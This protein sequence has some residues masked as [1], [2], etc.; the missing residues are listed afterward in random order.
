MNR[1]NSVAALGLLLAVGLAGC[2]DPVTSSPGTILEP[3]FADAGTTAVPGRVLLDEVDDISGANHQQLVAKIQSR[4]PN[5][6]IEPTGLA[7][8]THIYRVTVEPNQTEELMNLVRSESTVEHVE[9]SFQIEPYFEPND[10][11]YQEQWGMKKIH[12]ESSWNYSAGRGVVVAVI[13]TGV[14]C[15][16]RDGFK[17]LSDLEQTQCVPGWNFVSGHDHAYDDHGHGSHVAGTIAQST[18]NN[19]G[20]VGVAYQVRIMPIKVLA[21][22][23]G[24]TS[25]NVADGIRWAADH[26][27]QVI[28]MSLG[29]SQRSAVIEE[30]CTHA[31]KKGVTIVA[32]AGN[33][34]PSNNTVG[35]PAGYDHVIAVSA[36]D[37][38]G[39]ITSFS[40]RGKQVDIGAPGAAIMQQT[41][42]PGGK[43]EQYATWNGTSMASPHVAG[44]AALVVS[45][46]V[47]DPDA[48]EEIL[49]ESSESNEVTDGNPQLYGAG[50]LDASAAMRKVVI[51]QGLT[52]LGLLALFSGILYYFLRRKEENSAQ[53]S[54]L[55]LESKLVKS[56]FFVPAL[57]SSVGFFFLPMLGLHLPMAF[58]RP[59]FDLDLTLGMNVHQW[60]PLATTLIPAGLTVLTWKW[61]IARIL[62]G[63]LAMGSATY[64]ASI[65]ALGGIWN[66]LGFIFQGW[67]ALN[68]VGSMA[69]AYWNLK[70]R[71]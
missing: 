57:L 38:T 16:T 40:S 21:A 67:I 30:A 68:L 56:L 7:E 70:E 22:Q 59:L 52:K 65:L 64:L 71:I 63:G 20:G 4:F 11:M 61:S 51:Q 12:T 66:P 5:A 32:A 2:S 8:E 35:Y 9:P 37:S 28:N 1:L 17:K 53:A 60:L 33:S 27:A 50:L 48:V 39:K 10:P 69:L 46:G 23:G 14:A 42:T 36:I 31:Y 24:G 54:M 25:E 3:T 55:S 62:N 47:N 34:G 26:G 6:Q 49:K 41:V 29:S 13:D 43:G 58:T 45:M 18:N 15:E 44:V 19:L